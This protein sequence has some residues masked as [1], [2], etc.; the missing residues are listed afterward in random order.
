MTRFLCWGD[1]ELM[2]GLVNDAIKF[3]FLDLKEGAIVISLAPFQTAPSTRLTERTV[4]LSLSHHLCPLLT[5]P[6]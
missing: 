5:F 1:V 3:K 4:R 6:S 2:G